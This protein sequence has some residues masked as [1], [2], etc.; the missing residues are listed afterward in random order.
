MS[1]N[2]QDGKQDIIC[3]CSGTTAA[4]IERVVG[5][6]VTDLEGISQATGACSGC[7]GCEYEVGELLARLAAADPTDAT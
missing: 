5:R 1:A 7:G 6:G 3:P 4:Q 2:P